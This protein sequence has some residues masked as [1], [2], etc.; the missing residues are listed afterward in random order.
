MNRVPLSTPIVEIGF[1]TRALNALTA[2]GAHTLAD[3]IARGRKG[4][5][6]LPNVGGSTVIHI[7][8]MVTECGYTLETH[9]RIPLV[10]NDGIMRVGYDDKI[11]LVFPEAVIEENINSLIERGSR[12]TVGGPLEV[13]YLRVLV[14]RGV[15]KNLIFVWDEHQIVVDDDGMIYNWPTEWCDRCEGWLMELF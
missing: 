2:D 12:F 6:C 11:G 14:K 10:D 15:I 8:D 13:S 5:S 3:V 9:G 4:I 7:A 1:A